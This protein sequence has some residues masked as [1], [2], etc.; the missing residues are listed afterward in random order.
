MGIHIQQSIDISRFSS[1]KL[2]L[3]C[4]GKG[5][6]MNMTFIIIPISFSICI[7]L[8]NWYSHQ[9]VGRIQR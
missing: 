1:E 2:F 3:S 6:L 4:E 7:Y 5:I 9:N 8:V